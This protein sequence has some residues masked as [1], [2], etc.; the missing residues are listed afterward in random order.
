[1]QGRKDVFKDQY[2]Y[3]GLGYKIHQ[4]T[5]FKLFKLAAEMDIQELMEQTLGKLGECL[6][7]GK[8]PVTEEA[9]A[10]VY[11]STN[12]N[13]DVLKSGLIYGAMEEF[14][15]GGKVSEGSLWKRV[16]RVDADFDKEVAISIGYHIMRDVSECAL[17]K[18]YI[19]Q[20][21]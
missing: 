6:R 13:L 7:G 15:T 8:W 17:D 4:L 16:M 10:A 19:H 14:F 11:R 3:E 21:N 20:A 12:P 2:V 18:C 1:M 9:V 5:C